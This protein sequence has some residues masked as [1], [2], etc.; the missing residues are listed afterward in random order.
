MKNLYLEKSIEI[1]APAGKVWNVLTDPNLSRDWIR[2]WWH[3]F[4]VL[5]SDWQAGSA[6]LWKMCNGSVGA[7]GILLV[8]EPYWDLAFTFSVLGAGFEKQ[9]IISFKLR[10]INDTT[11][12][13]VTVGNFGDSPEHEAC[14]PGAVDSWNKSLPKI[15][16]LAEVRVKVV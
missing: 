5:E 16:N 3:E 13:A 11:L 2:T 10:E 8:S 14:F 6:V 1:E 15:K 4:D 9:E 12:L 7:E